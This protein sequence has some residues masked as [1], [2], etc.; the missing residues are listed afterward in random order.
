M[1]GNMLSKL[2]PFED[3]GEFYSPARLFK[4]EQDIKAKLY[5]VRCFNLEQQKRVLDFYSIKTDDRLSMTQQLQTAI[6]LDP[7]AAFDLLEREQLFPD[8][9]IKMFAWQIRDQDGQ[10]DFLFEDKDVRF[11]FLNRQNKLAQYVS[12]ITARESNRWANQDT[13]HI[14]VTVDRQDLIS[15]INN[16]FKLYDFIKEKLEKYG[17]SYLEIC[18]EKDLESMFSSYSTLTK[19]K[20]WLESQGIK[21]SYR[22]KSNEL[23]KQ[24]NSPLKEKIKNF[25]EIADLAQQFGIN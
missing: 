13:S 21:T 6:N 18:Y 9:I 17:R 20:D 24:N 11:I 19:I 23:L 2:D 3:I 25:E 10:F 16:E 12:F 15:Y 7:K 8:R 4:K 22:F 1:L 5:F 14:K